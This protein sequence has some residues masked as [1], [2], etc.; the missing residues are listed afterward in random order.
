MIKYA[1]IVFLISSDR[2]L[3]DALVDQF[4]LLNLFKFQILPNISDLK[5]VNNKDLIIF[6]DINHVGD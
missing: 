1:Q 6:N 2:D 4:K 5:E 3:N